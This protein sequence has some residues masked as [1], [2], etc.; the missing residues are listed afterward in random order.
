MNHSC[1]FH[2]AAQFSGRSGPVGEIAGSHVA[3]WHLLDG[4]R[5]TRFHL[6][7][8]GTKI[9]KLKEK[10]AISSFRLATALQRITK[11]CKKNV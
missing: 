2:A 4:V 1:T 10:T 7:L 9:V 8:T 3:S 5:S 6:D 11:I